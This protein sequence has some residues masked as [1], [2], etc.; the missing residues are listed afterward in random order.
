MRKCYTCTVRKNQ[1]IR[2]S[3]AWICP[4]CF[5]SA[6]LYKLYSSHSLLL[7]RHP[8][9]SLGGYVTSRMLLLASIFVPPG[10]DIKPVRR[11]EHFS[12]GTQNFAEFHWRNHFYFKTA[13]SNFSPCACSQELGQRPSA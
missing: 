2:A 5:C 1:D 10:I 9:S 12:A 3:L 4:C 11:G 6:L 7:H 8:L 13:E